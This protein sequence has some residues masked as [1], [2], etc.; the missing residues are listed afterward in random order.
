LNKNTWLFNR[1]VEI[2]NRLTIMFL[3]YAPC[4]YQ[5]GVLEEE[6]QWGDHEIDGKMSYREMQ[7]TCSGFGTGRL[8]QEMR[9]SGGRRLRRSQSENGPKHRR[10]RICA[11]CYIFF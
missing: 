7:P 10:R 9:R 11:P 4:R 2:Q 1:Y 8:E 5:E 3:L 6:G